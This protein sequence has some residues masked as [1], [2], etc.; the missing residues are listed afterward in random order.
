MVAAPR[1]N[2]FIMVQSR[3][4]N[5]Y[6]KFSEL[7]IFFKSLRFLKI[8]TVNITNVTIY[9]SRLYNDFHYPP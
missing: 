5:R 3:P 7:E 6:E 1:D 4:I 8:L 9:R 2:E